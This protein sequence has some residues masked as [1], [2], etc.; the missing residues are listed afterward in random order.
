MKTIMKV[1]VGV[2]LVV[3]LCIAWEAVEYVQL[4]SERAHPTY[5]ALQIYTNPIGADVFCD[6]IYEGNTGHRR[7]FVE[8]LIGD[9]V[10]IT[11]EKSGYHTVE[12]RIQITPDPPDARVYGSP[13][14][15]DRTRYYGLKTVRIEL[16]KKQFW[17]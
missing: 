17:E 9:T 13:E 1:V 5:G 2:L 12:R 16:Q 10:T 15:S 14:L 7:V 8:R 4:E 6:G 3:I 11:V